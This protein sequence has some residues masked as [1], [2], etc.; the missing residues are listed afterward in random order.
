[1]FTPTAFAARA[2]GL[3]GVP[4]VLGASTAKLA[5]GGRPKALDCSEAVELLC[6]ENGTPNPGTADTQFAVRAKI[7]T[8]P[9]CVG[10]VVA[11]KNNSKRPH[12]IGHIAIVYGGSKGVQRVT[13]GRWAV[14]GTPLV[15]ES[16]GQVEDTVLT[17]LPFWKRRRYYAGIR[18]LHNFRLADPAAVELAAF[19][20]LLW[21]V[22]LS[23]WAGVPWSKRRAA[24]A[25]RCRKVLD[26]T[27]PAGASLLALNEIS[28]A[29]A[30]DLAGLL[31]DHYR[32]YH[33]GMLRAILVD[34]RVWTVTGQ[35]SANFGG[36][37]VHGYLILE[38]KHRATGRVGN[39]V[40]VHLNHKAA[41]TRKQQL[42][43]VLGKVR[44]WSDP[45]TIVGDF[46]AQPAE[47]DPQMAAAGFSSLRTGATSSIR[48]DYRTTDKFAAGGRI[49]DHIYTRDATRRGYRVLDGISY[50]SDH[51]AVLG[52]IS[53]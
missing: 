5:P 51:N 39:L 12:G 1:M 38:L 50:G 15:L 47:I 7:F 24:I 3:K 20:L 21:N 8:G 10:D 40:L 48:P 30:T 44:A 32:A 33:S 31:G 11:L 46:N 37:E 43:L 41:K 18:R 17:D 42:Q 28:K 27:T 23:R 2:R 25:D 53:I 22:E 13:A 35:W 26:D 36:D 16:R 29:E 14:L 4:Y 52:Q 34:T 9:V 6:R 49:I 19:R 45:T